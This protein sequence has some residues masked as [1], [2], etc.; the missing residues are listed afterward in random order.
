[1]NHRYDAAVLWPL[2][3]LV[4]HADVRPGVQQGLDD[5]HGTSLAQIRNY[6]N[7]LWI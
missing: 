4:H 3:L 7:V 5:V 6:V 1:L 2:A